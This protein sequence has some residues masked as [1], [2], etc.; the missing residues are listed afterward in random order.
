ML[1]LI[2]PNCLQSNAHFPI[3]YF[4]CAQGLSKEKCVH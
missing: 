4:S 2:Y 3:K 1:G